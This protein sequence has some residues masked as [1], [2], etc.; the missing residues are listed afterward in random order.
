MVTAPRIGIH[1]LSRLTPVDK[2]DRVALIKYVGPILW[3]DGNLRV[4]PTAAQ[5]CR[6]VVRTIPPRGTVNVYTET[7]RVTAM[8][9]RRHELSTAIAP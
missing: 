6:G 9:S 2:A 8:T 3:P 1:L 4:A 5:A 7:V